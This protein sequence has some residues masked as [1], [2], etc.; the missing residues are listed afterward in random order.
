[1]CFYPVINVTNVT[2][3]DKVTFVTPEVMVTN[4]LRS[5]NLRFVTCH[6]VTL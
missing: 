6:F 5:I 4:H 1:M 3:D 2:N